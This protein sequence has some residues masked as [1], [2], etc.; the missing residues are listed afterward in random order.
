MNSF[1]GLFGVRLINSL[2]LKLT[3]FLTRSLDRECLG[4]AIYKNDNS[5]YQMEKSFLFNQQVSDRTQGDLE[6]G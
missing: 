5:T 1:V 3:K 2:M 6:N 4:K